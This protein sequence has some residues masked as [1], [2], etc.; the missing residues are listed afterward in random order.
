MFRFL[1]ALVAKFTGLFAAK[2]DRMHEDPHV[3]GAAYDESIRRDID[4]FDTVKD[5]VATLTAI[6]EEKKD[7]VGRATER[8]EK[9]SNIMQAALG[10]MKKRT[11]A[12]AAANPGIEKE[13][14]KA[15]LREDAEWA[16]HNE[17]YVTEKDKLEEAEAEAEAQSETLAEISAN[18]KTHLTQLG[19]LQRQIADKRTEKA[20]AIA[21]TT[22]AKKLDQ[23][24]SATIGVASNRTDE[25]LEQARN[26]RKR[27]KARS[28]VTTTLAGADA[29]VQD[30]E[31]LRHASAAEVDNELDD[32]LGL[33]DIVETKDEATL[34]DPVI[35]E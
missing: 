24:Q 11:A 5:A 6:E 7:E 26:A 18:L 2:A 12:I 3:M 9:V 21:D 17:R 30:E 28:K 14:L 15:K 32:L 35:K 4:D 1:R 33:D 29:D 20:S 22:L 13:S 23:V 31:Y 27:A 34:A 16:R 25:A 8:V 19:R 10:L